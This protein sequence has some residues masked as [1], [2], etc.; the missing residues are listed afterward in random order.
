MWIADGW[1]DYEVL[2]CSDGE[3]LER[4][5]KYTLV[6]PDPQVIWNTPRDKQLWQ[7]YDA[8]YARSSTGGGAWN[9]KKLPEKWKIHY[10]ELT[11]QVKPMNFKHTG[12][13]PEQATNWDWAMDKIRKAGRPISVLNLFAYTGGATLACAAAGAS[14]CHV[15]AARGMVS[16]ARENAAVSGLEDNYYGSPVLRKRT[17]RRS[18]EAGKKSLRFCQTLYRSSVGRSAVCHHQLLY[19]RA[20]SLCGGV[21]FRQLVQREIRGQ[22]CLRRAGASCDKIRP[23]SS[24]WSHGTLDPGGVI[25]KL[26]LK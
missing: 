5:G 2:D 13:F 26:Q 11:F 24:L 17:F 4:W 9:T 14:V 10:K 12:I 20:G 6:R 8:R 16:W 23:V 18:V 3:K 22:N 15:D 1:K 7:S 25:W 21:S 19:H